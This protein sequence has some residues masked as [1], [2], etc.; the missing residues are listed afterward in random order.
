MGPASLLQAVALLSLF[1][2]SRCE[3]AWEGY[4]SPFIHTEISTGGIEAICNV[5][6]NIAEYTYTLKHGLLRL[7]DPPSQKNSE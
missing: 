5:P 4:F 7:V 6:R 2:F 1:S 3:L